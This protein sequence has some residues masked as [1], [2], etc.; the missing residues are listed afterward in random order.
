MSEKWL[1]EN[2]FTAQNMFFF[3]KTA[4]IDNWMSYLEHASGN[5][6]LLT[7]TKQNKNKTQTNKAPKLGSTSEWYHIN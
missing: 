3:L 5:W 2:K 1:S 7:T 6:Q 4:K